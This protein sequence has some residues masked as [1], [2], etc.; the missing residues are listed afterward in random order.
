MR[1]ILATIIVFL[2]L[3]AAISVAVAWGCALWSPAAADVHFFG[4]DHPATDWVARHVPAGWRV[5]NGN[6]R[7]IVLQT[8]LR[9]I[10]LQGLVLGLRRE[11]SSDMVWPPERTLD[12]RRCGW[13]AF[14]FEGDLTTDT[15]AQVPN[16]ELDA[17]WNGCVPAPAF[18]HP[19]ANP[20]G[21]SRA[22]RALPLRPIS[23]GLA[24]NTLFYTAACWTLL[25][26]PSTLRR[27]RRQRHGLCLKCG[28]PVRGLVNCPECGGAVSSGGPP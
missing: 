3:G 22:P 26:G 7:L 12:V 11:N 9:G 1:R 19:R 14:A 2:L 24:L 16:Q 20:A 5:S 17:V 23:L 8:T 18:L 10:G 27:Q 25:R 28:Y 13:P 21:S 4:D 15:I 6:D